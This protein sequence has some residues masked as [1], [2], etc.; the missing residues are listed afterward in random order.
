MRLFAERGNVQ[1][2]QLFEVEALFQTVVPDV[3]QA[4]PFQ[5]SLSLA[6]WIETCTVVTPL[7]VAPGSLAVPQM[8]GVLQ[9]AVHPAALYA[10]HSGK[11]RP[12][13][14]SSDPTFTT[15]L[16]ALTADQEL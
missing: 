5:Y 16:D 4:V 13:L 9:P 6:R 14:G 3:T 12:R 11:R 1:F 10:W 15:L 8:P 2:A 7:A